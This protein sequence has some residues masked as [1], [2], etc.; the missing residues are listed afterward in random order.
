MT[1]D[2]RPLTTNALILAS[3]QTRL[4]VIV[5]LFLQGSNKAHVVILV[6]HSYCTMKPR[7][8]FQHDCAYAYLRHNHSGSVLRPFGA[9]NKHSQMTKHCTICRPILIRLRLR[10]YGALIGPHYT[11]LAVRS[12]T[13]SQQKTY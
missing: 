13:P 2:P 3:I 9:F 12:L 11:E 10:Q 4:F 5:A 7:E 6:R 8:R 1:A